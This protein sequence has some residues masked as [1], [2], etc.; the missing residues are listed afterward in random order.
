MIVAIGTRL[1]IMLLPSIRHKAN[2]QA[3]KVLGSRKQILL[4]N[5]MCEPIKHLHFKP[6]NWD[7]L[8]IFI[9]C[10]QFYFLCYSL[11][12]MSFYTICTK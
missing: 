2:Y 4:M 8:G 6:V 9:G 5:C 7:K 10:L 11:L 12:V 3:C 1:L